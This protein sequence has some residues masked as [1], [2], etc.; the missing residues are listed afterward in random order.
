MANK[1]YITT[2]L[3]YVNA[4]PHIGFG[5]EITEADVIARYRRQLGEQ[6]VF[7]TG[8]DEHGSKIY[9]KAQ[10][11]GLDTQAYVDEYAAKFLNLKDLLNLSFNNFIRTTDDHHIQAAQEFWR[12]CAQNG[13]IYK[14][15][16]EVKYCVGCELEKTESELVEGRCPDHPN[17]ELEIREEENYYFKFSKYQQALLD[18]YEEHE[19]F[20]K[21]AAKQKEISNFV[22]RG[23]QD[24]SI[25]RLANKMPWGIP[26]PGDEKHVM[27]VWFDALVNY[28]STLGWPDENSNFSSYWPV[29]Q[30]A[31]KDNLRQQA[32]MWQAM[33]LSAKLPPSKKIL[34]NGHITMNGQKM[35][36]SLGNVISP[37]ELVE[38]YGIDG[39]RYSMLSLT[40]FDGDPDVTWER[41]D[42]Q[43][44]GNLANGLG[45]LCSRV[46]KM[47]QKAELHYQGDTA[48]F[49]ST[50]LKH[51]NSYDLTAAL[52]WIFEQ[53]A[54]TDQFLSEQKPWKK[55]GSVQAKILQQAMERIVN[56]AYH[57]QPFMPETAEIIMKHFTA[58]QVEAITPLFP[59]I[60]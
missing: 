14:A 55:E 31:G 5:W 49:N 32:A 53:V 47:A 15:T 21:P 24:F 13:D 45:N 11:R 4:D 35:S 12:R 38:K 18:L 59:R 9:Q 8:T 37:R 26:V 7:N 40:T 57:L 46:A 41:L 60:K 36:K 58:D 39:A 25:S 30:I 10:A 52:E 51:M 1:F 3:P 50:Y 23:L 48:A 19:S 2:T 43:Y 54:A 56:I 42:N 34:I 6:V 44:T 17:R 29:V 16:Y 20:I 28:V 33:L 27:Y 22:A